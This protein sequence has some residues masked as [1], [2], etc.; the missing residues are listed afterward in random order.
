MMSL[1]IKLGTSKK[2]LTLPRVKFSE[3]SQ[4]T[5]SSFHKASNTLQTSAQSTT[6]PQSCL[7][8]IVTRLSESQRK[9]PSK[10]LQRNLANTVTTSVTKS[11]KSIQQA[12]LMSLVR[13][14]SALQPLSSV[15]KGNVCLL[16]LKIMRV[17]LATLFC[18]RELQ[19]E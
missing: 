16:L 11:K 15:L 2:S 9:Q 3:V 1:S 10:F 17:T 6:A 13:K 19:N 14:L 8:K 18:S 5:L 7:K 12:T 4:R